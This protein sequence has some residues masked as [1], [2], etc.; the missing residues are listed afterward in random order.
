[1]ANVRKHMRGEQLDLFSERGAHC[2]LAAPSPGRLHLGQLVD[3]DQVCGQGGLVQAGS[4][5]LASN[6]CCNTPHE[7]GD[8]KQ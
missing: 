3:E 2:L 6:G 1:M 4:L 5:A 8:L 7:L